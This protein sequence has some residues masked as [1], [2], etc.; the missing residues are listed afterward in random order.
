[1]ADVL[2]WGWVV[3]VTSGDDE[4]A[5]WAVAGA[6]LPDLVAVEAL[7]R[8]QLSARRRGGSIRLR[9]VCPELGELLD[10]VGLRREVGGE[11]EGGEEVGVEEGVEPGDP[12]A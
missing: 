1:M 10:L 8:W 12:V 4:V 11:T 3:L 9:D 2:A 6:G 5:S 7:A